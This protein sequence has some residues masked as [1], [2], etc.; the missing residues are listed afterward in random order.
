VNYA[1][2]YNV[3]CCWMVALIGLAAVRELRKAD[4]LSQAWQAYGYFW[5]FAACLWFLAGLRLLAYFKGWP[6]MDRMLFYVDEVFA[7]LN[8]IAGVAF[9]LL[10]LWGK[11]RVTQAVLVFCS[12]SVVVFWLMLVI[13]GVS[14][15]VNTPWA[16]EHELPRAAFYAFL[17]GYLPCL[18]LIIY[19]TIRDVVERIGKG[20][21]SNFNYA[22]AT[23]T[24]G[25]YA[26]GGIADVRGIWAGWQLLLIRLLYMIAALAAFWVA[27]SDRPQIRVIRK[28]EGR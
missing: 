21:W 17:P 2:L 9:L 6:R 24:M 8:V 11:N 19:A 4:N 12:L 22:L 10:R 1:V 15:T 26:A 16:S 23:M 5:L 14:S 13:Y 27:R 3:F 25:L 20:E 18:F 7:G 28:A